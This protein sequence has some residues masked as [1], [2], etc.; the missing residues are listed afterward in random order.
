MSAFLNMKVAEEVQCS[1][2]TTKLPFTLHSLTVIPLFF[3]SRDNLSF[4]TFI[5]LAIEHRKV[6]V[7]AYSD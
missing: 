5:I 7:L 3:C 1:D 2:S 6:F 4:L